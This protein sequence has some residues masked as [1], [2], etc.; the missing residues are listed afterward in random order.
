[1][2]LKNN[3]DEQKIVSVLQGDGFYISRILARETS[4]GQSSRMFYRAAEGVPFKW[5]MQPGTPKNPQE[6]EAIPPLSPSPLMQSLGLSLPNVDDHDEPKESALKT[7]IIWSLKKM[8]NKSI[9]S[10]ISKKVEL[11]GRRSKQ[12]ESS[13]FGDSNEEF[14]AS[15]KDSSFSSNSSSSLFSSNSRV[16]DTSTIDSPFCCSPWN[17][18]A[19]LDEGNTRIYYCSQHKTAFAVEEDGSF[20]SRILSR[21][22]AADQFSGPLQ[23]DITPAGVPFRWEM[24]PGT[25]KIPP[26]NELIPPPS[27]PPAVQSLALPLPRLHAGEDKAKDSTWTRAWFWIRSDDDK[28]KETGQ[29]QNEISFRYHENMDV[30]SSDE[31]FD[32]SFRESGSVSSSSSS[33]SSL[34]KGAWRVS[35]IRRSF[36]GSHFSCGPWSR[37]DILVFA[38]RK[39]KS[40]TS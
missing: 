6:E 9:I 38:R 40:F 7:S 4:S 25:P 16:V 34:S 17:V 36:Q 37:R 32:A 11:L 12:Q 27:P 5:E 35:K 23:N 29:M 14:V 8:V 28:K 22:S 18:P 24:Q 2:E 19:I 3:H 10:D 21:V 31:E 39:F 1:M 13:R 26:E 30:C 33:F 15:V 20:L